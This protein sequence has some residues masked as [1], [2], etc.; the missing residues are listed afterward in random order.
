MS[1]S[2]SCT[3]V[4]IRKVSCDSRGLPPSKDCTP[5]PLNSSEITHSPLSVENTWASCRR[6][7]PYCLKVNAQHTNWS[8][9]RF[10]AIFSKQN[11]SIRLNMSP[12]SRTHTWMNTNILLTM[13][14]SKLN[15]CELETY[16]I[17]N[18]LF[19]T[20]VACSLRESWAG[21][22]TYVSN[23]TALW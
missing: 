5:R 12:L 19:C 18:S 4:G 10:V 23:P 1:R 6:M 7:L 11:R 15:V 22:L 21:G 16:G 13:P 20:N 9:V 14:C 2:S 3:C 8:V 17:I